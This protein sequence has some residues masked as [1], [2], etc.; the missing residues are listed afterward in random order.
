MSAKNSK[1]D[2]KLNANQNERSGCLYAIL[3]LF[4]GSKASTSRKTDELPFRV[5]DN[6][7]SAAEVSFYHVL[8]SAIG[9][10]FTI[11]PKV[12]L[13]DIFY[14]IRPN[15]N[16]AAFN[17]TNQ[18]HVD[19]LLCDAKSMKPVLGIELDDSS[20]NR[21]ARKQRDDL[22]NAIFKVAKLPMLHI[23]AK[24]SYNIT[25]IALQVKQSVAS[26]NSE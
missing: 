3:R 12:R 4:G 25:D 14:V 5:R 6:F 19:F 8:K 26:G 24:Q 15:E 11:C 7:L 16:R 9:N 22:V 18:K 21:D 13:T 20:H 1:S 23:P 10:E 17:S 2:H